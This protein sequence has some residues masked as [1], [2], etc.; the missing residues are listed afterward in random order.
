MASLRVGFLGRSIDYIYSHPVL[1]DVYR[2]MTARGV[3]VVSIFPSPEMPRLD[4]VRIDCDLYVLKPGNELALS[5][6]GI[7]YDRGARILNSYEASAYV[8]DKFR[9]TARLFEVG[10]PSPRS[11]VAHGSYTSIQK[12]HDVSGLVIKPHRGSG[13]KGVRIIGQEEC[14]SGGSESLEF[15]Q[16]YLVSDGEDL[17]VYVI[18]Q[19]ISAIKRVFSAKTLVEKLGRP[20][21]VTQQVRTMALTCGKLFNLEIYSMDVIETA[22]GPFIVDVNFFPGFVGVPGG[23]ELLADYIISAATRDI[24]SDQNITTNAY[25]Q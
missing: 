9:V 17:K 15:M 11:F 7:L 20:V 1:A 6:A 12:T 2:I 14:A 23:A 5:L 24:N 22:V 19:E 18:G 8:K 4:D 13:S 25:S 16:E 3:Q 21:Q 10:L